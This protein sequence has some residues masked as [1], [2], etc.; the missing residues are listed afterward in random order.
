MSEPANK[1]IYICSDSRKARE[2]CWSTAIL[3][4]TTEN[5]LPYK[6]SCALSGLH[7]SCFS[8]PLLAP[9][10]AELGFISLP[11][12]SHTAVPTLL[13]PACP[14]SY[15]VVCHPACLCPLMSACFH[16]CRLTQASP[17]L[18]LTFSL[19]FILPHTL[20][21]SIVPLPYHFAIQGSPASPSPITLSIPIS[22]SLQLPSSLPPLPVSALCVC[23]VT[24]SGDAKSTHLCMDAEAVCL[25]LLYSI[26]HFSFYSFSLINGNIKAKKRVTDKQ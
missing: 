26:I 1:S 4:T 3:Q 11:F 13:P 16:P 2:I 8:L 17:A 22:F 20:G 5:V 24:F 21:S 14:P 15:P 19:L 10:L 7:T 9:V 12:L 23:P 6:P 25:P 18:L